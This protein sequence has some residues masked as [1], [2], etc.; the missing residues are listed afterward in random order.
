MAGMGYARREAMPAG[1]VEQ[2][3]FDCRL[4][5]AIAA[6]RPS[7]CHLSG[8]DLDARAVHPDGAAVE[9]MLHIAAQRLDQMLSAL[10]SKAD[11]VDDDV[12]PQRPDPAAE[13]AGLFLGVPVRHQCF[14]RVPSGIGRIGLA[15]S[16]ADIDDV[17]AGSDQA[18]HQIGA[19]VTAAADDH[20]SWHGALRCVF[21]TLARGDAA[22]E[23]R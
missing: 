2:I 15:L 20:C 21:A 3:G 8:W 5:R 1:L 7:R 12:G 10:E 11:H 23:R 14:D 18:R 22:G 6:D 19:D 16:P 9:K 17:V 4:L 13:R